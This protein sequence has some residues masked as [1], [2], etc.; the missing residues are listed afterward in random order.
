[1]TAS[2]LLLST[3]GSIWALYVGHGLLI[4]FL[5]NGAVYAPLLMLWGGGDEL[6]DAERCNAAAD[7]DDVVAVRIL[8]PK[9]GKSLS[10]P[11]VELP[12]DL[13]VDAPWGAFDERRDYIE[14]G[15]DR[16]RDRELRGD[17]TLKIF[18]DRQADVELL[19]WTGAGVL[20]VT[21]RVGD[22]KLAL[23]AAG[24]QNIRS[25]VL[26]RVQVGAKVS[27]SEPVEVRL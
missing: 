26:A 9:S 20:S 25:N 8:N 11:Q 2:G 10:S 22:L 1:M 18:S 6:I 24:L 4:G 19:D 17:P 15:L 21:A 3:H 16:N 23:P 27:W 5:G 13:E 14:I 12:V 7:R